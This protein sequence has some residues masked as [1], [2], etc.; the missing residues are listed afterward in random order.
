MLILS[1]I[2]TVVKVEV[3]VDLIGSNNHVLVFVKELTDETELLD[4]K[5]FA[6]RIVRTVDCKYLRIVSESVSKDFSVKDESSIFQEQRYIGDFKLQDII[7]VHEVRK[8]RFKG[9]NMVTR[10]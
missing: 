6:C 7:E 4:I 10:F 5:D 2:V 3:V 1:V 8:A 9:Y